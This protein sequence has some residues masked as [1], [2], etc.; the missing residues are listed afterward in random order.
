MKAS[1]NPAWTPASPVTDTAL[2]NLENALKALEV[3]A[4][5]PAASLA[6]RLILVTADGRVYRDTGA[7]VAALALLTDVTN[8]TGAAAGAHPAT[9]ISNIPSGNV[10]ATT[11][12]AA[13]TELDAEKGGLA[14]ANTWAERQKFNGG[15]TDGD[16]NQDVSF[17]QAFGLATDTRSWTV[18][19]WDATNPDLPVHIDVIDGASTVVATL[20]FTYNLA[21]KPTQLVIVAG[22]K[23]VTITQAFNNLTQFAG[24][25]KAVI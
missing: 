6:G 1:G 21:G 3:L 7:A 13:I 17:L 11:V 12:Q 24:R 18:T 25:T 8:H 14:Q 22:G 2:N 5:A 9:A 15:I 4:A 19:A 16:G 10:A 20:D 23:T